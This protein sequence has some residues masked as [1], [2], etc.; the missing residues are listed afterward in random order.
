M[1]HGSPGDP[2]AES[3]A[4]STG[5]EERRAFRLGVA[6]SLGVLTVIATALAVYAVRQILILAFIALFVA[7][8]LEPAVHAMTRRGLARGWAVTIVLVGVTLLI[9]G[10]IAA[11]VPTLVSQ[12]DILAE[13]L[14]GYIEDAQTKWRTLRLFGDRVPIT[15][16]LAG[17]ATTLPERLSRSLFSFAGRFF[18]V[19]SSALLVMVLAVYFVADLPRLRRGIVT[20]FPL[21]RR[22]YARTATDVV[23]DKVGAYMIGNL[24]ISAIAGGLSLIAFVSLGVPYAL[25]LAVVVAITDLIPL[26]GATI[27]AVFCTVIAVFTVGLWP[28][29]VVLAIFFI[30]YQQLENYWIAP[31]VLRGSVDLPEVAVLL[32]GLLGATVLGLVGALMAIPIA[33]VVK[34]LISPDLRTARALAGTPPPDLTPPSYK[35]S[36]AEPA[37]GSGEALTSPGEPPAG[38]GETAA[39]GSS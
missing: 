25:P 19:V 34:V 30:A 9:A 14:P 37:E 38:V 7:V 31:R 13:K 8:S 18:G 23:V 33:A 21:S 35:E 1:S 10:F 39:G 22:A 29:A 32:A 4:M 15:D 24:V 3:I 5:Q 16:R 11:V 26:V 12:G 17:F 20:L 36:S 2:I 6:T 27:G 28:R